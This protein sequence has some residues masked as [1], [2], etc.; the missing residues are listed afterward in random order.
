MSKETYTYQTRPTIS[1]KD[2]QKRVRRRR[3]PTVQDIC[4]KRPVYSKRDLY[5]SKETNDIL[6]GNTY[7]KRDQ[8]IRIRRR[9]AP[10]PCGQRHMSKETHLQQKRPIYVQRDKKKIQ[11]KCIQQE[12]PTLTHRMCQCRFLLLYTF[13]FEFF[14]AKNSKKN[15]YSKRNLHWRIRR[16]PPCGPRHMSKEIYLQQKRPIQIKRDL[17][18]AKTCQICQSLIVSVFDRRGPHRC[19][20]MFD[21][22]GPHQGFF[23]YT[24]RSLLTSSS[25][26][27]GPQEVQKDVCLWQDIKRCLLMFVKDII[28]W[29]LWTSFDIFGHLWTSFDVCQRL[30]SFDVCQAKSVEDVKNVEKIVKNV[31]EN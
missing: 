22:R 25:D 27:F 5:T 6:K 17:H 28:F 15:V 16:A 29:C 4:Q 30:T 9:R 12:K 8:Q 13:F 24:P 21:N 20:L 26:I 23:S 1:K 14:R 7:S 18:T 19:L 2:Q 10:Q 31:L 3:A 11:K